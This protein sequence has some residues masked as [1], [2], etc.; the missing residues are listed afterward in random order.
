[1][2]DAL[3]NF[4]AIAAGLD[5][6]PPVLFLDYDGTLTPIVDHPEAAILAPAMRDRLERLAVRFRVAVIS[7]R[8]LVDVRERVRIEKLIYAGSHGFDIQSPEIRLEQPRA[9]GYLPALD[10][11]ERQLHEDLDKEPGV[12]IE[13]KHFSIA[14]HYRRVPEGEQAAIR[15]SVN[16]LADHKH[17][18]VTHGK[19]VIELQPPV[20]WDKGHALLW[21]MEAL[22]IDPDAVT[23]V[24][25][26][27]DI[28]DEDAFKVLPAHGV[29]ILVGTHEGPSVARYRLAD[30]GAVA[31]WFDRLLANT[32]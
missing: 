30:P 27:D 31:H 8:D 25:L 6:R 4:D 9:R 10:A 5:R 2:R 23:P 32:Y 20:A 19:K 7:G 28:T 3:A 14:V 13:R 15:E 26:G 22:A 16:A 29:G 1:M 11:A 24:Y 17:L 21:L 18:R 12:L